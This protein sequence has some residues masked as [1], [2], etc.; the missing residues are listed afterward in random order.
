MA[1]ITVAEDAGGEALEL[2]REQVL[3]VSAGFGVYEGGETWPSCSVRRL[4]NVWLD[5]VA[6]VSNPTYPDARVLTVRRGTPDLDKVLA[7]AR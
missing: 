3:D 1:K 5:H 7:G 6:L 2:A 4:T